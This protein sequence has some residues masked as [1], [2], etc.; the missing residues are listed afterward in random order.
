MIESDLVANPEDRYKTYSC[1]TQLSMKFHL[2]VKMLKNKDF[3]NS[4]MLYFSC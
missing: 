4:Q 2:P 3:D 1:S